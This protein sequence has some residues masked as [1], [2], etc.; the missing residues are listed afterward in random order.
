[1][2]YG[3]KATIRERIA[4]I[5]QKLWWKVT[6]YFA[7]RRIKPGGAKRSEAEEQLAR[8]LYETGIRPDA[9]SATT[10]NGGP[11][12]L[13]KHKDAQEAFIH[14]SYKVAADKVIEWL[15]AQGDEI[16]PQRQERAPLMTRKQRRSFERRRRHDRTNEE[17]KKVQKVQLKKIR[18]GRR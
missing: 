11:C 13:V 17:R 9:V 12:F 2:K 10:M 8:I 1:M 15:N 7:N 3:P 14:N 16:E 4:A 6:G 18:K 5:L